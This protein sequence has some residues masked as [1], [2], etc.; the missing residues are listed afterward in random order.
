MRLLDGGTEKQ[1]LACLKIQNNKLWC[2]H[3]DLLVCG[4]RRLIIDFAIV[5]K[6]ESGQALIVGNPE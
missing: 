3:I 5:I 1:K 6:H 2:S 4:C